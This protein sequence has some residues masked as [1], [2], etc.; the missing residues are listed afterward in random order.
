MMPDQL[1]LCLRFCRASSNGA[2]DVAY[3][4]LYAWGHAGQKDYE[5]EEEIA[6]ERARNLFLIVAR[7]DLA[8]EM[9]ENRLNETSIIS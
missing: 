4:A 9:D 6:F 8:I 5:S 1:A 3:T 7:H 2:A